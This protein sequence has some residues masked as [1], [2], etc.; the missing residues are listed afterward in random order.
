MKEESGIIH[1]ISRVL[2]DTA[3]MF[4]Y[5]PEEFKVCDTVGAAL[6]T[7]ITAHMGDLRLLIGREGRQ[8]RAFD[9]LADVMA[10]RFGFHGRTV[11]EPTPR[12]IYGECI[13]EESYI[14]H[15][16]THKPAFNP[17]FSAD[18]VYD[19]IVPVVRMALGD[20]DDIKVEERPNNDYA[21]FID[22][23]EEQTAIVTAINDLFFLLGK[24]NGRTL[25]VKTLNSKFESE[26]RKRAGV[27]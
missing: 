19:A 14:G 16:E 4:C 15:R 24:R 5:H 20:G 8:S 25:K 1:P 6:K 12:T 11:Q 22:V 26:Q 23:P 10:K 17:D 2:S 13:F 7:M 9:Y 27:A 21:V 18:Q 3:L